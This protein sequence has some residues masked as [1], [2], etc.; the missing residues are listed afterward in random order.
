ME[1]RMNKAYEFAKQAHEGQLRKYTDEPY[2]NHCERVAVNASNYMDSE[3][4]ADMV[5]TIAVLHDTIEDTD[6]TFA[7]IATAFGTKVAW[8]VLA[9]TEEGEGNRATRHARYN[10]KLGG[11]AEPIQIIKVFDMIDNCESLQELDPEWSQVYF[12]EKHLTLKELTKVPQSLQQDLR[13][14]LNA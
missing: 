10:E 14:I 1:K 5:Y 2:I 12:R 4:M 3:H 11:S 13:D 6:V 7:H 8:G 9:L